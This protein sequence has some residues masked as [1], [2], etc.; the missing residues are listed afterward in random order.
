MK[1]GSY[2]VSG[3]WPDA[4]TQVRVRIL[5]SVSVNHCK[6]NQKFVVKPFGNKNSP[7]Q[8]SVAGGRDWLSLCGLNL[9]QARSVYRPCGVESSWVCLLRLSHR[10]FEKRWLSSG[11]GGLWN[12]SVSWCYWEN[13][14]GQVIILGT[15]ACFM[16][17][18]ENCWLPPLKHRANSF[19][20]SFRQ[21]SNMSR[22]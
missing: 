17:K 22:E 18:M 2:L 10:C 13:M 12:G 3:N 16:H 19:F 5:S 14:L 15:R 7:A 1:G 4:V 6:S 11:G 9:S 21:T 20:H 8:S